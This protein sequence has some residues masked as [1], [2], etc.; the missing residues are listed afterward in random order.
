MLGAGAGGVV[1]CGGN[2][3]AGRG[4]F[5]VT[6]VGSGIGVENEGKAV[7]CAGGG[8]VT[9]FIVVGVVTGF[10]ASAGLAVVTGGVE[11]VVLPVPAELTVPPVGVLMTRFNVS[12]C[13]GS[14]AGFFGSI[15]I[16]SIYFMISYLKMFVKATSQI[17]FI[18]N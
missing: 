6:L 2:G 9:A 17:W 15:I 16:Y 5:L 4:L 14:R 7:G 8:G 18:S 12:C 10:G 13:F 3:V 11:G 1:A